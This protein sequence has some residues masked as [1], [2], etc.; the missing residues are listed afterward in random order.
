MDHD[1]DRLP[2]KQKE[3]NYKAVASRISPKGA[4]DNK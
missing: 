2:D 1:D 4:I 3:F